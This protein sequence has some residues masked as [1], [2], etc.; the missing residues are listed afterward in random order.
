[1]IIR[2]YRA[3]DWPSITSGIRIMAQKTFYPK[4]RKLQKKHESPTG[5]LRA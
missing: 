3:L 1:M 2:V 5:G 4:I